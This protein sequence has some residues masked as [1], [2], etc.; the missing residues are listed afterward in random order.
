VKRQWLVRSRCSNPI[1]PWN[2][3]DARS[4]GMG[5]AHGTSR[6]ANFYLGRQRMPSLRIRLRKFDRAL[7]LSDLAYQEQ[8]GKERA[9]M[10]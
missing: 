10:N 4:R 3:W 8:I 2:I 5:I 7:N 9:K 6:A 1:Q